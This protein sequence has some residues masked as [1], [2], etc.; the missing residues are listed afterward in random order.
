MPRYYLHRE[1]TPNAGNTALSLKR[2]MPQWRGRRL[3][4]APKSVTIF[5]ETFQYNVVNLRGSLSNLTTVNNRTHHNKNQYSNE[6]RQSTNKER[7]P[8]IQHEMKSI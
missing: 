6:R 5:S 1:Q 4:E 2:G 8:G 3:A 7:K